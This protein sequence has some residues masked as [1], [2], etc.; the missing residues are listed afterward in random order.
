MPLKEEL[1]KIEDMFTDVLGSWAEQR[2][3]IAAL[4]AIPASA[5]CVALKDEL[6]AIK[7]AAAAAVARTA[8]A[9]SASN[10]E[11]T[12][13][14]DEL[15]TKYQCIKQ[16]YPR[17]TSFQ[18]GLDDH[19]IQQ[20]GRRIMDVYD[21]LFNGVARMYLALKSDEPDKSRCIIQITNNPYAKVKDGKVTLDD[22]AIKNKAIEIAQTKVGVV[23]VTEVEN[24]LRQAVAEQVQILKGTPVTFSDLTTDNETTN[25]TVIQV[26]TEPTPSLQEMR[27]TT[28][29][30]W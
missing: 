5:E 16:N 17:D 20:Q 22:V 14:L 27:P 10:I 12:D 23:P 8:A 28:A 24:E 26:G 11:T 13:S 19:A 4:K 1:D 30:D 29:N 9:L 25:P 15:R 3:E 7:A 2:E 18:D 6:D 21:K